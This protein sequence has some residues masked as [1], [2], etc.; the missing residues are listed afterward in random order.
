MY[1]APNDTTTD[2]IPHCVRTC[3]C[4]IVPNYPGSN[5][6][7][8]HEESP[9]VGWQALLFIIALMSVSDR[10]HCQGPSWHQ[11]ADVIIIE[12]CVAYIVCTSVL[13]HWEMSYENQT[14][15]HTEIICVCRPTTGSWDLTY[16]C[17]L[18]LS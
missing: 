11:V 4:I 16:V 13:Q 18:T 2:W 3:P 8:L 10:V 5:C 15:F 7:S 6:A 1:S 12:Q 9:L 17:F 14:D